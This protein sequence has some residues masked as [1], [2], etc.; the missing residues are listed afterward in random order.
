MSIDAVYI[1]DQVH[2]VVAI[3]AAI[4]PFI[5]PIRHYPALL[6]F[7]ILILLDWVEDGKCYLTVL[8]AIVGPKENKNDIEDEVGFVTRQIMEISGNDKID[9]TTVDYVLTVSM[10]FNTLYTM[11]VLINH[12]NIWM[13]PNPLVGVFFVIAFGTFLLSKVYAPPNI[14]EKGDI[15]GPE[16]NPCA[17]KG[18]GLGGVTLT[19]HGCSAFNHDYF[20]EPNVSAIWCKKR[21][22]ADD[23]CKAGVTTKY[24][25]TLYSNCRALQQID[26]E[27][28]LKSD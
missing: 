14:Y 26:F 4:G 17:G 16:E 28:Y 25:C 10:A 1:I 18:E 11:Y 12:L 13:F 19:H 21:C 15:H 23:K 22:V 20:F 8:S 24:G 3:Y 2:M 5:T 27:L 6:L 9:N 7:Y